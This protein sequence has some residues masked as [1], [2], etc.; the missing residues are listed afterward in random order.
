MTSVLDFIHF[1]SLTGGMSIKEV[2]AKFGVQQACVL[3]WKKRA[4]E[5]GVEIQVLRSEDGIPR[6]TCDPFESKLVLAK[7]IDG[8]E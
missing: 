3:K 6:Y 5:V 8:E 2:Q 1:A 4:E 7:A